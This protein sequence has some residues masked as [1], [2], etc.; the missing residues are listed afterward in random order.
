MLGGKD[1]MGTLL[2]FLVLTGVTDVRRD[3]QLLMLLLF[4]FLAGS[5]VRK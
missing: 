2:L 4:I 1:G 3:E 5:F